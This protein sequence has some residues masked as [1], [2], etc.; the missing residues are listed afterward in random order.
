MGNQLPVN[1][2]V[3]WQSAAGGG[4]SKV[5]GRNFVGICRRLAVMGTWASIARLSLGKLLQWPT[6]NGM[7]EQLPGLVFLWLLEDKQGFFLPV[8]DRHC[9]G[10]L[11]RGSCISV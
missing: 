10:Y 5:F 11:I 4:T 9:L 2:R 6:V 8:V 7:G 1:Q 3:Q